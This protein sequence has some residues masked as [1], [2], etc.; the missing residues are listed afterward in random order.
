MPGTQ[1]LDCE[2]QGL[3]S[4]RFAWPQVLRMLTDGTIQ[5]A[6]TVSAF[7]LLS[8]KGLLPR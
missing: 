4:R 5:D 1:K 7:G 8:L 3:I 6:M 2:E